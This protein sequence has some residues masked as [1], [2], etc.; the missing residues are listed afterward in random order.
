MKS[1]VKFLPQPNTHDSV[2]PAIDPSHKPIFLLDWELTLKCNLDCSYCADGTDTSAGHYSLADHP[3]TNE[4]LKTIDFMFKYVDLYMTYKPNWTKQVILNLYGGESLTHPDIVAI[5]EKTKDEYSY[6]KSK[7]PLKITCTTNAI[8]GP[9]RMKAVT[10][11][12]EEFTVSYHCENIPKQNQ[13]FLANLKIIK[14]S[15]CDLKVI[16]L[17]HHDQKYWPEL[18][19]VM[20]YCEQ[21]SIKYLPR[22]LDGNFEYNAYQQNWFLNFYKNKTITKSKKVQEEELSNIG[23]ENNSGTMNNVGRACCGGRNFCADENYRKP[24]PYIVNNNFKNWFCSVNWFFVYIKQHTRDIYTNKDCIMNFDNVPGPI[25]SLDHAEDL[26]IWTEQKLASG[27]M[28]VIRCAKNKC[29][30]GLCAPKAKEFKKFKSIM[31]K[32]QLQDTLVDCATRNTNG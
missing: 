31:Q 21:N 13:Q 7:W 2:E 1:Q 20:N 6:Y 25:G 4:C 12:I 28:P 18:F 27:N 9:K 26:L 3:D 24:I 11:Y 17:M 14:E 16:I 22:Q 19:E 10:Q 30:C 29:A 8:I 32:H 5:L 15:G 23:E